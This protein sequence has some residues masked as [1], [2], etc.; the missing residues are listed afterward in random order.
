MAIEKISTNDILLWAFYELGASEDFI[1]VEAAFIRA[2]EIAPMRFSWR[3]RDD[4]VNFKTCSLA[5]GALGRQIPRPLIDRGEYF[6]MISANGQQW[7]EENHDRLIKELERGSVNKASNRRNTSRLLTQLKN[8]D[9]YVDWNKSKTIAP[10]KW[11]IAVVLRCS[12]DSATS[13]FNN[14]IEVLRSA[15]KAAGDIEITEFLNQLF[16]SKKDWFI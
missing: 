13:V 10:D 1:D 4:L 16:E 8:S 5:L 14:R 7:L 11:K 9:V 3:T 6:R 12:P 2:F 15:S